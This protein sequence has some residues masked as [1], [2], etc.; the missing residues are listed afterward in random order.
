MKYK[1]RIL[2]ALLKK[3]FI[4]I[5]RN[6]LVPRVILMLPIMTMLVIP[7]VATLD[8]K[9]VGVAIVD[10]DHSQLSRRIISDIS[11]SEYLGVTAVCN[12]FSEAM[13][14]LESGNTDAVL[15]IPYDYEKKIL[16]GQPHDIDIEANGVNAT[17]GSLGAQ[18]TLQSVSGTLAQFMAD[19]GMAIPPQSITVQNLYNP[20]LNFRNYMIPGLIVI[21]VIMICGFLPTLNLVSE[22]ENGTIEAM[23]VTPVGKFTFVL[24]KLIPYWLIGLLIVTIGMLIGYWVYGLRPVGS[25]PGFYLAAILFSLIMSGFGVTVANKSDTMMQSIFVMFAVVMIFQLMSGL[26]TPI[27]SMP[28]WSQYL[29]YGIPPRYFIEIMRALY[30]RGTP[31]SELWVQFTAL[32]VFAVGFCISAAL[33]YKKTN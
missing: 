20:T 24:S 9:H 32:G 25:V 1:I 8:V 18:Y 33:T 7:L 31:L 21:L 12:S 22:K 15:T 27:A 3:E 5:K 16:T 19:N 10:N 28:K 14:T 2:K 23:N 30:L 29:T 4:L 11:A 26:F 6:P 17:K 13:H